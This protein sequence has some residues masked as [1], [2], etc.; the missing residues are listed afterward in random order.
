MIASYGGAI[1]DSKGNRVFP[2]SG[3]MV[4]GL[5]EPGKNYSYI[6]GGGSQYN[7]FTPR[8][9][10]DPRDPGDGD[11][12]DLDPRSPFCGGGGGGGRVC[13]G[14]PG[15]PPIDPPPIDPPP[16]TC[17][18]DPSCPPIYPHDP[19]C[20]GDPSCPPEVIPGGITGIIQR[21]LGATPLNNSGPVYLFTPQPGEAA[22]AGGLDMKNL[23]IIAVIGL[24]AWFAYS[25]L[26]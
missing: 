11:P 15:C 24:I 16:P 5:S 3:G 26:S 21:L 4:G 20:P 19:V 9:N 2:G 12:C 7:S 6:L 23:A 25:K 22:A 13:P 14:D 18:G 8:E 17:P 10:L 1:I